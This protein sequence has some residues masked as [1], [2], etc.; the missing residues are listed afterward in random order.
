M[1]QV[2]GLTVGGGSLADK[3]LVVS[4]KEMRQINKEI[5]R[6]AIALVQSD[7][8]AGRRS[9][10]HRTWTTAGDQIT[11]PKLTG[12]IGPDIAPT[13]KVHRRFTPRSRDVI[14][15]RSHRRNTQ[16]DEGIPCLQIATTFLSELGICRRRDLLDEALTE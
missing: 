6:L 8:L 1:Q 3:P 10:V 13:P 5:G 7:S 2:P 16:I 11:L 15:M 14:A 12:L 9:R 4:R